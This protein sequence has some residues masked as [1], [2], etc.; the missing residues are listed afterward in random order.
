M[1]N[2][3]EYPSPPRGVAMH[4]I[5]E[6]NP[7]GCVDEKENENMTGHLANETEDSPAAKSATSSQS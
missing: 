3:I 1:R 6:L 2:D 4:D 5:S 7:A